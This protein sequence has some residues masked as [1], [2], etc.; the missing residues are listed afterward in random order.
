MFIIFYHSDILE[1]VHY[2]FHMLKVLLLFALF[3]RSTKIKSGS[4]PKPPFSF[5]KER[6]ILLS[7]TSS[8]HL[9]SS[10]PNTVF[11][12]NLLE[13]DL[14]I[15]PVYNCTHSELLCLFLIYLK[16]QRFQFFLEV[17][18]NQVYLLFHLKFRTYQLV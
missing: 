13:N 7:I 1:F 2:I 5:S 16:Y 15:L 14:F 11:I 6:F 9:G 8:I 3:L 12:L 18:L 17:Q 10:C 4:F